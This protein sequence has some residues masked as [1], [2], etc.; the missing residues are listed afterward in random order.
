MAASVD[1][2]NIHEL[3]VVP[4]EGDKVRQIEWIYALEVFW[5]CF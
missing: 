1:Y 3:G 4:K 2:D 5:F